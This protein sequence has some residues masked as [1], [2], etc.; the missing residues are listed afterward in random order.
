[1]ADQNVSH[2]FILAITYCRSI[3]WSEMTDQNGE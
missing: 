2:F 1:M 3:F